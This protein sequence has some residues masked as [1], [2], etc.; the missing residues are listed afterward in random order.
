[1]DVGGYFWIMVQSNKLLSG[2][3]VKSGRMQSLCL[4]FTHFCN[5]VSS[6][7]TYTSKASN[8]YI[9]FSHRNLRRSLKCSKVIGMSWLSWYRFSKVVIEIVFSRI[10]SGSISSCSNKTM[11]NNC[12]RIIHLFFKRYG[13]VAQVYST[14]ISYKQETDLRAELFGVLVLITSGKFS[15]EI[16]IDCDMGALFSKSNIFSMT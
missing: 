9:L 10:L 4:F 5:Y 14:F 2:V 8:L 3:D 15:F 16:Y 11:N 13:F 6:T 7:P 1:M 12:V